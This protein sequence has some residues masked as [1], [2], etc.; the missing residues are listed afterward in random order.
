MKK[1]TILALTLLLTVFTLVSCGKHPIEKFEET[2]NKADSYLLTLTMENSLIG[3]ITM[4]NQID[5]NITYTSAYLDIPAQYT[6]ELEDVTY[7]YTQNNTGQWEKSVQPEENDN[8]DMLLFEDEL[9]DP[10][11]YEEIKNKS[12]SYKQREDVVFS[13]ISDVIITIGKNN[14]T[15]EMKMILDGITVDVKMVYSRLNKIE[16][17]LPSI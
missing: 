9:F 7:V 4:T 8:M 16:L 13:G 1:I 17:T 12:N 14:Y 6:E 3:S 10:D 5:G 11:N 2:M 15:M